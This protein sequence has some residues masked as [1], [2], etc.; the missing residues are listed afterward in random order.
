VSDRRFPPVEPVRRRPLLF[1]TLALGAAAAWGGARPGAP[2]T[3]EIEAPDG[4]VV[5][6]DLYGEGGRGVVLAPGARFRKESWEEQARA[7]ADAGFRVV[8]IDFRGRGASRGPGDDDP[9]AARLELDVLA[10]ARF[11]RAHGALSVAVVGASL[12]GFSA[13]RAAIAAPGEIDRLVL[14]AASP[15]EAPERLPG[16]KLFIVARDDPG[17]GGRPRLEAIRDQH[18]RAPEP[19]ELLVVEGGAHAQFLFGTDEGPRVLAAILRFLAA[20]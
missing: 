18:A 19:K 6:A 2:E 10:A 13:A 4:G 12:G 8:A 5:S 15:V 16:R 7:L 1:A 11:L 20:P 3:I 17:P 14:L 9:H